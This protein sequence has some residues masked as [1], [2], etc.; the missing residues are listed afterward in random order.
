MHT[1]VI[2]GSACWCE[3]HR[4]TILAALGD[5]LCLGGDSAAAAAA[6]VVEGKEEGKEQRCIFW[7][8]PTALLAKDGWD[9]ASSSFSSVSGAEE[10][11]GEFEERERDLSHA[12]A[13][14]PLSIIREHDSLFHV[15]ALGGQKTGFYC[16]QRDNRQL[17]RRMSRGRTVLDLYCYT[18]GFS[19][20]AIKGGALRV[21]AVDSSVAALEIAKANVTLNNMSVGSATSSSSSSSGGL[22]GSDGSGT[23]VDL[24]R[25]DAIAFM[26][27]AI[28]SGDKYDIVICDPPKL[29]PTKK[30]LDRAVGTY[31][32][33]NTLAMQLVRP[34]GLLLTCTCSGAMTQDQNLYRKVLSQA[35]KHAKR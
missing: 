1:V 13:S 30:S 23:G 24:V 31:T 14:G 11:G 21:T 12:S 35:A 28:A 19:I 9:S 26:R 3:V 18:G 33:I 7:K 16:D 25:A 29:A 8:T 15:E 17:I 32:L 2:Q 10:A 6:A 27:A 5:V 34:G 4:N 22:V 20:N